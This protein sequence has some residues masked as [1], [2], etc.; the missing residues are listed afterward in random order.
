MRNVATLADT[1]EG[2]KDGRP[3]KAMT[4]DHSTTVLTHAKDD[5]LHAY[6]VL[7]LLTGVRT[8]EARALGR[9]AV[10]P[11]VQPVLGGPVGENFVSPP[12]RGCLVPARCVRPG[13]GVRSHR[14]H[15]W[16]RPTMKLV[17]WPR[18][19]AADMGQANA[20]AAA[21]PH[22]RDRHTLVS[23]CTSQLRLREPNGEPTLTGRAPCRP[24]YSDDR[25]R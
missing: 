18:S 22:Y 19:G 14:P 8:E 13:R 3:S 7:S 2:K 6:V 16:V 23:R 10:E 15:A 20:S 17:S 1:P 9:P 5:P 21:I 24:T 25:C 4:L 12:D 11:F